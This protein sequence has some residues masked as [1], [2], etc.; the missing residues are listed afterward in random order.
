MFTVGS[1]VRARGREWVVLPGSTPDWILARPLGGVDEEET[2]ICT[3][4]ETIEPAAFAPPESNRLGDASSCRLLRDAI[5]LSVRAGAGP[6]RCFGRLSVAPRPYQLVPLLMALRLDPVRLFIADDVGVGKTVEAALIAA[7]LLARGESKRLAV[8]CPP[9]LAEQWRDELGR[10]FNLDAQLV[11]PGTAARLERNLL[12]GQSVFQLHP[13]VVVSTDFIK[14]ERRR[15]EFVR[16]CPELVIVDEAHACA[17]GAGGRGGRHQR[18]ELMRRLAADP[19]RHMIFVSATPHSGNEESFRSLLSLLDASFAEL[20]AQLGGKEN[21]PFRRRLAERFIQRRRGDIR[22]Y[23]DADTP[24]PRREELEISYKLT[25]EYRRLFDKVLAYARESVADEAGGARRRI[26]WWSALALLRALASSPAAAAATLRARAAN[27]DAASPEEADEIGRRIVLDLEDDENA[28]R[29][30]VTPGCDDETDDDEPRTRRRLH[31]LAR[32][33]DALRGDADEKLTRV[34]G[35]IRQL[36]DDEYRPII[37][38]RFLATADYVTEELRRR[39]SKSV[40]IAS[41]TGGLP[42]DERETRIA[43]LMTHERRILVCTD[44]L[45]EGVNLQE[46]FDAVVHYDLSWNPTRH[47]QREGRVDRFGQTRERVRAVAYYGADNQIDG[48]VLDALI[49]KHRTIRS[50]LGVSVPVPV[51]TNQVMEAIFEGLLLRGAKTEQMSLFHGDAFAPELTAFHAEWDLARER[52]EKRSRTLFAQHSVKVE[53]VAAHLDAERRAVGAGV[54]VRR[55]VRDAFRLHGAAVAELDGD[56]LRIDARETPAALRDAVGEPLRFVAAFESP[57]PESA[58]RLHRTHRIVEGV[59]A[60]VLDSALDPAASGAARRAG[61][62]VTPAVSRRTT[63]LVLRLRYHLVTTFDDVERTALAEECRVV[64]FAGS[65]QSADWLADE[66][67][68]ALLAAEPGANIAEDRAAGFVEKVVDGFEA[69]RPRL[70]AYARE[71][72]AELLTA[73]ESVRQATRRATVR[74]RVAPQLPV[75]AL[76]IFV[77]LPLG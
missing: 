23:M 38:C 28:E 72:A 61:V 35:V 58:L 77:Y 17:F 11:L 41:V 5:R 19:Q 25:P 6:F 49:R 54:D 56:A 12:H 48:I 66:D 60:Y 7:E 4:L 55:F 14:S 10:K 69:L 46:G 68:E 64:A 50:Q 52:E 45:S 31:D 44:C 75:D 37:F 43:D 47:E 15:D 53:E 30:D 34:V 36:L 71:R 42:P 76:G 2:G 24:F 3:A 13:L 33:A 73:H 70:D 67:A 21:E 57:G 18:F 62:I 63:A 39:L 27:A 1:L 32:E 65:P 22:G 40:T 16:T 51:E 8:L 29:I 20:P 74:H 26:R 9:H 59:S